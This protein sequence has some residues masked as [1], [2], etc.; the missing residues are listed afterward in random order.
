MENQHPLPPIYI[1]GGGVLVSSVGKHGVEL[2][3]IS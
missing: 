3:V 2:E 1:R